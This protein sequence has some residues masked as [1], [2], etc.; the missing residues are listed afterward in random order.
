MQTL[1][2][3][4]TRFGDLLQTQPALTACARNGQR[5]GL[6]CLENFAQATRLL[7]DL[8][9]VQA[10]PGAALLAALDQDW[11][12][13][14]RLALQ[15]G[16]SAAHDF[17][18]TR[19]ANLTATLPLRLLTRQIALATEREHRRR[20]ELLGFAL[21][22]HG[23]GYC[24]SLWTTFLQAASLKRGCSPFNLVDL[25]CKSA[26]LERGP[27]P[28][29]LKEPGPDARHTA[30]A[31]LGAPPDGC[32]GF[33]ALQLGASEDRRRWP[34]AHF[35][36]LGRLLRERLSLM[37]VLLGSKGERP[38]AERY[39]AHGA[40]GVDCCGRT[41]LEEL[42]GV[43]CR[44]ALLVSNDTGTMHLAAGLGRPVVAVFLATA[45]PWDTGPYAPGNI[46]LEP[47]LPCH[48]CDF[49]STCPHDLACRRSI[50]P[51]T[52]LA[53]VE[54]LRGGTTTP[55][56]GYPGARVWATALDPDGFMGLVCHS[57]HELTDRT[58]WV[59]LQR[60]VYRQFLD[61]A[62]L[63]ERVPDCRL[64]PEARAELLAALSGA[65]RL[66]ELMLQ[67][68]T[69]LAQAPREA[70]KL[71]FLSTWQRVQAVLA[72]SPR[73]NVL[74][75]LFSVE[76]QESGHDLAA[77]LAYIRRYHGLTTALERLL[78]D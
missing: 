38:L 59:R 43:L 55:P 9:Y 56:V 70:L 47:D 54:L 68:A 75:H 25:F 51:E 69:V 71:K 61:Q 65:S 60:L 67:Q 62:P 27:W 52:M 39:L 12:E 48:P 34:V 18:P 35:A 45:Q 23:F 3:N 22:E 10:L 5:T 11:R 73:L 49:G 64:S 19:I 31:L 16:R 8:D 40:P 21:D 4:C 7:A 44:C 1:F 36:A 26:G 15:V 50:G 53:A 63:P 14:L 20:P 28:N 17:A 58:Q 77:V 42:A 46:C 24:P 29:R 76:S 37:P 6:L 57:Q 33:V 66:L 41:G 2:V 72:Q 30:Q 78:A 74:A 13:A 32:T